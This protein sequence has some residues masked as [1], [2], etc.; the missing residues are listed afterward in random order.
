MADSG[1]NWD[2]TWTSAGTSVDGDTVTDTNSAT[3]DTISLDG[4]AAC[5]IGIEIGVGDTGDPADYC[6]IE[7]QGGV[8]DDI[9]FEDSATGTPWSFQIPMAAANRN[10][11]TYKQF[12]VDAG[13]YDDFRVKF[14]NECAQDDVTITMTYK[15][16][17]IPPAS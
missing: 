2:A 9:D 17:T 12:L 6:E 13:S 3:S 14:T 7:V 8:N 11:S 16:A 4:K 1:Y 15:T 5:L 10:T